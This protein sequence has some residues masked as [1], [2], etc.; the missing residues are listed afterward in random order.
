MTLSPLAPQHLQFPPPPPPHKKKR[1]KKLSTNNFHLL[2]QFLKYTYIQICGENT[3]A[4]THIHD[5]IKHDLN[6][7]SSDFY[8]HIVYLHDCEASPF[9]SM[10]FGEGGLVLGY[11]C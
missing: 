1:N 8:T 3:H 7:I 6:T 11:S 4:R 5:L 10:G 9:S 2:N